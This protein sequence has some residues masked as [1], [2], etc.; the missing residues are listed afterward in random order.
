MLSLHLE[1]VLNFCKYINIISKSNFD[2][3]YCIVKHM[4]VFNLLLYIE[5][6]L[7]YKVF[8]CS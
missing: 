5:N 4:R 2:K 6:I 1:N 8:A 3:I 7:H